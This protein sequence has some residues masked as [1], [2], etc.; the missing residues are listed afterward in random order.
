MVAIGEASR[1]SGVAIETIRYYEREGIIARAGRTDSGR[2]DYGD[3]EI[4]E[5]LFIRRCRD[6]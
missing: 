2:R 3:A 4:A 5:L 1:R 6:M